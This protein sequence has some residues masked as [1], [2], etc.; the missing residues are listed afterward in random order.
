METS[1]ILRMLYKALSV[2]S[3]IFKIIDAP[4]FQRL[5]SITQNSL[6]SEPESPKIEIEPAILNKGV[7]TAENLLIGRVYMYNEVYLHNIVLYY[8][9]VAQKYLTH[10]LS[11]AL[12]SRIHK[13]NNVNML[14]KI[15]SCLNT[16]V[17][18]Y[19]KSVN[20]ATRIRE[21]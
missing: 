12:N 8:N 14:C 11:I 6:D 2:C 21:A 4:I 16:V 3:G 9:T 13:C 1:A 19:N 18:K 17:E 15:I 20:R 5:R 7:S 10:L